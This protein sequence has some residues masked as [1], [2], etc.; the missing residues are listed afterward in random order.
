M[1]RISWFALWL[2]NVFLRKLFVIWTPIY[3]NFHTWDNLSV[4][5]DNSIRR[6]KTPLGSRPLV[7]AEF[8]GQR[9]NCQDWP[10]VIERQQKTHWVLVQP[11]R[12]WT[13]TVEL[14]VQLWGVAGECVWIN[15][16]KNLRWNW[17]EKI[18]KY[19]VTPAV[20]LST[21]DYKL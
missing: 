8:I 9:G 1:F 2:Y 4:L 6:E 14:C 5:T 12:N 15:K 21:A 13:L 19:T 20:I 7:L 17:Q 16:N 10:Q 18:E 3:F 11:A